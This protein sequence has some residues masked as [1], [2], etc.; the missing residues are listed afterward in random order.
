MAL[1]AFVLYAI[2]A[3][4]HLVLICSTLDLLL[5]RHS[6]EQLASCLFSCTC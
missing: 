6:A 2:L 3:Y 4:P 5:Y 1:G